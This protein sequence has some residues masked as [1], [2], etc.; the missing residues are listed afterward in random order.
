MSFIRD[1]IDLSITLSNT[2][3]TSVLP[4]FLNDIIYGSQ[5]KKMKKLIS[6][7]PDDTIPFDALFDFVRSV[8]VSNYDHNLKYAKYKDIDIISNGDKINSYSIHTKFNINNSNTI[9]YVD[10]DQRIL[11][12]REVVDSKYIYSLKIRIA[13]ID[14]KGYSKLYFTNLNDYQE[15]SKNVL[16]ELKKSIYRVSWF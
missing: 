5:L 11:G 13:L 4:K 15:I 7:I 9:A 3:T 14:E 1:I 12:M 2:Y 10:L 8:Y 6:K 16:Q